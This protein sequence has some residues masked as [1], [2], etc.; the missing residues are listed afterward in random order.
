MS[1]AAIGLMTGRVALPDEQL[2]VA[3]LLDTFHL[4]AASRTV[5]EGLGID[6]VRAMSGQGQELLR[7]TAQETLR[8]VGVSPRDVDALIHIPQRVPDKFLLA[9]GPRVAMS[10]GLENAQVLGSGELGCASS[11]AAVE[12]GRALLLANPGW[13]YVLITHVASSATV[14]RLRLPVTINGD[15]VL[16]L[17]MGRS[18]VKY[19]LMASETLVSGRFWDLFS[20]DYKGIPTRDWDEVCANARAYSFDLAMKTKEDTQYLVDKV[21]R[22]AG[23]SVADVSLVTPNLSSSSHAFY[24]QIVGKSVPRVAT[25]N[26]QNLGHLGPADVFIN[27]FALADA[28]SGNFVL[29]LNNSPVA[30]N[31]SIW[32]VHDQLT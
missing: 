9:D 27:M 31:A 21:L 29:A 12:L 25:L 15:A 4:D 19:E 6:A 22:T 17:L 3:N 10:L 23:V 28:D 13:N 7:D 26:L 11:S 1:G 5:V 16:V 14:R 20:I 18:Y 8:E 32:R 2:R 24:Q 30:W